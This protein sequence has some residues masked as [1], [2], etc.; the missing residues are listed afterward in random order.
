MRELGRS[1]SS[2]KRSSFRTTTIF[3]FSSTPS[4]SS[5]MVTPKASA[6]LPSAPRDG[7]TRKFSNLDSTL[8]VRPVRS[9]N[10]SSVSCRS[11]RTLRMCCASWIRFTGAK[12]ATRMDRKS[13]N[14]QRLLIICQH[15]GVSRAF[16]SGCVQRKSN[17]LG[18]PWEC[19]YRHKWLFWCCAHRHDVTVLSGYSSDLS[20]I[21][22]SVLTIRLSSMR[23]TRSNT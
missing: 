19:G 9:A 6:M 1:R 16:A 23:S 21:P 10:C 4:S 15:V 13:N 5:D 18:W 22:R 3:G 2:G 12:C 11:V 8:L 17:P 7:V 14:S 20:G